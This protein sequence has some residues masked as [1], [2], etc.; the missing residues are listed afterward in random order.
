MNTPRERRDSARP[1]VPSDAEPRPNEGVA[2]RESIAASPLDD[3][4]DWLRNPRRGLGEVSPAF[5][6]FLLICVL[7]VVAIAAWAEA[8]VPSGGR[9]TLNL[10][11]HEKRL[12]SKAAYRARRSADDTFRE[13]ERERVREWRRNNRDKTRARKRKVRADNCHRPFVPLDAEGQNYPGYDILYD[14]VRYPKHE[15]HLWGA[16]SDDGRPPS[17]LVAAGTRGLDERP[18]TAVQI[19]DWLLSLKE[20]FGQA[21]FVMFSFGYDITQILK[22]LPY[23]KAWQIEK[24]ETYPDQN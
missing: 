15:T 5:K 16:A 21:I 7:A 9:S 10:S 3:F 12:A 8:N 1:A 4:V 23:E 6:I 2:D 22:H 18:L 19:L 14:G 20:Q 11:A 24:R 13:S 17:W